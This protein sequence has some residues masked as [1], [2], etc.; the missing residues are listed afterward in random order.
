MFEGILACELFGDGKTQCIEGAGACAWRSERSQLIR[1]CLRLSSSV[2]HPFESSMRRIAWP[3][4][5]SLLIVAVI[6]LMK[7]FLG[8]G[9]DV[10]LF[11]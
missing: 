6:S 1:S 10:P 9:L 2:R 11:L 7:I 4:C 8:C 3:W 5:W